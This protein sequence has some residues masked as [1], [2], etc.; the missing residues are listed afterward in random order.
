MT[1][2]IPRWEWR[3]FVPHAAMIDDAFTG[4][5]PTGVAESD[6]TYFLADPSANV[7]IRDDLL[8]IKL[9]REVGADGLERWEP[10]LKRAFPLPP[11]DV[12]T[13][14]AALGIAAAAPTAD[15]VSREAF[16]AIVD[17]SAR[18]R[19]APVHKRRVRYT[20]GG[21]MAERS[22]VDVAGHPT[23]TVAVE[24]DDRRAGIGA[25][26]VVVAEA[27]ADARNLG[28]RAS[29]PRPA[30]V[31]ARRCSR[32]AETAGRAGETPALHTA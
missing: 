30:G 24:S 3:T 4:L 32:P 9:L 11:A 15:G 22:E 28:V 2:I 23:L 13:V 26:G 12:G 7:K 21:C 17:G 14:L 8:D 5:S 25:D 1:T 31:L 27:A 10:V 6:E 29:R 16:Q 19:T 18:V 20:I